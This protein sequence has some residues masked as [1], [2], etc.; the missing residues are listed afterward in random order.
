MIITYVNYTNDTLESYAGVLD[1][2]PFFVFLCNFL[3]DNLSA[4]SN[5]Y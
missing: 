1:N 5:L 4:E 3:V 2:C